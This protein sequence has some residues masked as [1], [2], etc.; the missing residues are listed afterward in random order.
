MAFLGN[1][2]G[3]AGGPRT[4]DDRVRSDARQHIGSPDGGVRGQGIEGCRRAEGCG[5]V[6]DA[7][8]RPGLDARQW[9]CLA[10]RPRTAETRQL[11]DLVG[12]ISLEDA[13]GLHSV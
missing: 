1:C 6:P 13:N 7:L 5:D 11:L 4:V 12:L 10:L 3:G 8:A 9:V 2:T